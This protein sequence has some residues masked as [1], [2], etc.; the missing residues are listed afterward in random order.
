MGADFWRLW[1]ASA[2][3]NLGDGAAGVAGPLLVASI[4]DR[5]A[6]V[7][8]RRSPS[9]CRGCCSRCPAAPGSTGWRGGGCW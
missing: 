3:S 4:T 2:I 8:G 6:L 5:P 7:A 1:A 9:S